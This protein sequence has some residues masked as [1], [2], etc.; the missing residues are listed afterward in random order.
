MVQ[1]LCINFKATRKADPNADPAI[2]GINNPKNAE[3]EITDCKLY[4]PVVTLPTDYENKLHEKLIKGF[5]YNLYWNRY[6]CQITN[7]TA[8]LINYLIDPVFDRL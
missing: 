5:T 3:F 7:Q 1:K 6:V 4:V 2:V 8:G